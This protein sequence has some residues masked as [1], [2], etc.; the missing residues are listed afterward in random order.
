MELDAVINEVRRLKVEKN[1]VILG[2]NYMEY[3]VQ[4]ISDYTGDSYDLALKA[5]STRAEL[6][7]FAGVFFM[8]EQ[9]AALNPDK[10]VLSPEPRAGCT[11]SDSL[12]VDELRR[13]REMYPNAPVVLYVNTSASVKAIADYVVTSSTA[14][15]VIKKIPNDTVIFGPDLNLANY[16]QL[17]IG[18]SK[19]IIKVPQNGRCIVHSGYNIDMVKAARMRH[20]NALLM[21]HPESP[22]EVLKQADFVG[23]TNQMIEYAKSS[24]AKEFIVATEIGM[25]N[26]LRIKVPGKVFYPLVNLDEYGYARCPYMAMVTLDKVYRSLRDEVHE[27]KLPKSIADVVKDAFERTIKLLEGGVA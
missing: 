26:S 16:V 27:V 1:A 18:N 22:I 5:M 21:A 19:R 17:L 11:L 13:Y 25:L 4:L 2:H 24:G 20:P 6:I 14:V 23:S 9:A 12:S 3:A 7:V 15:K 10:K 8:V